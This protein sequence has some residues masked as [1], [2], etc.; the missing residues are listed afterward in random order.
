MA[1]RE[2]ILEKLYKFLDTKNLEEITLYEGFGI[3]KEGK[4]LFET[5]LTFEEIKNILEDFLQ[6]SKS[7]HIISSPY[8]PNWDYLPIYDLCLRSKNLE[9][10]WIPQ[11]LSL[12]GS[13][14]Y[15]EEEPRDIDVVLRMSEK[16]EAD[17][18]LNLK[19]IR[20]G[21]EIEDSNF[22]LVLVP[23]DYEVQTV[24]D[25]ENAKKL[26]VKI[27][28]TKN[29][30]LEREAL[31]SK[32]KDEVKPN[33]MIIPGKPEFSAVN[34]Y[35]SGEVFK[36]DDLLEQLRAYSKR[37]N[38]EFIPLAVQMK[39]DG[40]RHLI[41]KYGEDVK[42]IS[43][44][45]TD[46]TKKFPEHIEKLRKIPHDL[47]LDSEIELFEKDIHLPRE[48]MAGALHAKYP[49]E[50]NRHFVINVFDCL[51]LDEDIHKKPYE[52]RL[53]VL[54]EL[55]KYFDGVEDWERYKTKLNLLKTYIANSEKEL[56]KIIKQILD[57]K[58][59]EGAMVKPL[60]SEYSLDGRV[61]WWKFKKYAEAHCIVYDKKQTKD[62][63]A[64]NYFVGVE[65]TPE[66][67]IP[68]EDIK[69]VGKIKVVPVATT[70][71]TKVNVPI[72]G[73]VTIAFH[74]LNVYEGK[75]NLYEPI[76]VEYNSSLQEPDTLS[77]LIETARSAGILNLKTEIKK[78]L[79]WLP[80]WVPEDREYKYMIHRH[81]R[82]KSVVD[83]TP[84]Y[85]LRGGSFDIIPIYV[86]FDSL[87]NANEKELKD[88]L[89]WTS[90]GWKKA[91]KVYRHPLKSDKVYRLITHSAIAEVT[92][93]HSLFS[94]GKEVAC[95]LL[96]KGKPIDLVSP[97]VIDANLDADEDIVKLIAA[98][99]ATGELVNRMV[100]IPS[101]FKELVE[102]LKKKY[103]LFRVEGDKLLIGGFGILNGCFA[104]KSKVFKRLPAVVYNWN[105]Q[106]KELF[107]ESLATF[108]GNKKHGWTADN[109]QLAEGIV[110]LLKIL[111]KSVSIGKYKDIYTI[112][113]T[114]REENILMQKIE[115][116]ENSE[117]YY[118]DSKFVYD[119]E[120]ETG[121]FVGGVGCIRYH[122]SSHLDFRAEID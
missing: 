113:I 13:I 75:V 40:A 70:Y 25:N 89:V 122:N 20:I 121:D 111:G 21:W 30:K 24:Y 116:K 67:Q 86:L 54:K 43:E 41:F 81:F 88:I 15:N 64:W 96:G 78:S 102:K 58:D 32:K 28:R 62:G 76:F 105:S 109:P 4:P 57:I 16:L 27:F 48:E 93:S 73:I 49:L 26:L 118:P 108:Q 77:S 72:G 104:G 18:S 44:D 115:S 91:L 99:V 106:L 38:T 53:E 65:Y 47:V 39:V 34:A 82:G 17:A 101:K 3:L 98:V 23:R 2:T 11:F 33:R 69:E 114:E 107:L 1:Q 29:K 7:L 50:E 60:D 36:I 51:Y 22:D 85:V 55:E 56:T 19:M 100:L 90:Q 92:G 10:V 66:I 110:F 14:V 8:G 95:S 97:P 42:I 35:R 63:N 37:K 12:T 61:N 46:N 94:E 120:T 80:L 74:N 79:S 45:G 71:N 31:E 103:D 68:P 112:T 87:T 6:S 84:I 9:L 117:F 119:I 52:E 59:S 5:G 83:H